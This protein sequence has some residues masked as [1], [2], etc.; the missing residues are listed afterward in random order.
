MKFFPHLIL[1]IAALLPSFSFAEGPWKL[2][3]LMQAP[4]FEWVEKTQPVRGLVYDGQI[5]QGKTSKVF[6][7][8]ASPATLENREPAAGEKFPGVVL[9][10]GG[11][12]TAFK[13]WAQ[14][15][16][17]R[18]Y[19]AIAM[20]LAGSRPDES[21]PEKRTRLADGGPQQDH[22][23]KFDTMATEDVSDDWCYHAV[24]NGILAHSLLRSLPEVDAERTAV[25][26]I[27]WGGYTTCIVA[28]LDARFK[29]AVP[30]YG[31]GF[32]NDNSP[33]QTDLA[34]LKPDL[35]AKWVKT[36]D[37][38]IYL[39]DSKVPMFFVNGTN[40]KFYRLDSY[41]KSYDLVK[42][43]KNI[44]VTVN[45]S[46]GHGAGWTPK[47]IGLY[48]DNKLGI[49]NEKKLPLVT[50]SPEIKGSDVIVTFESEL[51]LKSATLSYAEPGANYHERKWVT[52]PAVITGNQITAPAPPSETDIYFFNATDERDA[53]VSSRVVIRKP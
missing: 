46:H 19:A 33:W 27:S 16:A 41:M 1:A 24:S 48:V 53:T 10:H 52:V 11:G 2:D 26:G 15:W 28:S 45:M 25:T 43:E 18:G 39:K 51:P 50:G 47:E 21:D 14:L 42:A 23:A 49:R 37:P 38:S 8:Y 5:Y 30:V 32:L 9:I 29:A 6:A 4:K 12:G 44:R 17:E 36:Y 22:L 35:A 7:Y 31:A 3:A 40:D 20:D 34:R 13:V